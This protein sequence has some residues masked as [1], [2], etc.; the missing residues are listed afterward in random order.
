M[1]F[2]TSEDLKKLKNQA[3]NDYK[4]KQEDIKYKKERLEKKR[5][6]LI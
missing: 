2:C 3:Y 6:N 5:L 4:S 1:N